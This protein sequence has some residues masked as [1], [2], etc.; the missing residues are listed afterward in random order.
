MVLDAAII[1]LIVELVRN[2][3]NGVCGRCPEWANRAV[4]PARFAKATLRLAEAFIRHPEALNRDTEALNWD[5]EASVRDTEALIRD[6]EAFIRDT[7]AFIRDTEAFIRDTEAFIR[8]WKTLPTAGKLLPNCFSLEYPEN[9]LQIPM[10]GIMIRQILA[11]QR[12]AATPP[13]SASKPIPT[14]AFRRTIQ[15]FHLL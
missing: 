10:C 11:L 14:G 15:L 2:I 8:A 13:L 4:A 6:T 1:S 9:L 5:T 12:G 3:T 7:E